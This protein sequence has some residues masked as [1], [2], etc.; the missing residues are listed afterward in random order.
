MSV[1][2]I[3]CSVNMKLPGFL[4]GSCLTWS[5]S[6]NSRPFAAGNHRHLH[7]EPKR[8]ITQIESPRKCI[9]Q[10]TDLP[11]SAGKHVVN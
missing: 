7:T 8:M 10:L 11:A 3:S 1:S 9:I 6:L 2:K 4:I 5:H